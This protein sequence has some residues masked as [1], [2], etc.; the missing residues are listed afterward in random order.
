MSHPTTS[1]SSSYA[2]S[3]SSMS[4]ES[5]TKQKGGFV[6]EPLESDVLFGRGKQTA[7]HPGNRRMHHIVDK[8]SIMYHFQLKAGKKK[9]AKQVYDEVMN[10]GTTRFLKRVAQP[11]QYGWIVVD[12]LT[13]MNKI[14]HALRCR[15]NANRLI[16][17]SQ[18]L[19]KRF[20]LLEG[21]TTAMPQPSKVSNESNASNLASI[22]TSTVFSRRQVDQQTHRGGTSSLRSDPTIVSAQE[23][24]TIAR[25]REQSTELERRLELTRN[26]LG[27]LPNPRN[28]MI[29]MQRSRLNHLLLLREMKN[30]AMLQRVARNNLNP[31][32]PFWIQLHY[33]ILWSC[34]DG[35]IRSRWWY[36]IRVIPADWSQHLLIVSTSTTC[37][38]WQVQ[39]H[40]LF[41]RIE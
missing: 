10:E 2:N 23:V 31:F 8:Y 6:K 25:R 15:K 40:C 32:P 3:S 4:G 14:G 29:E 7:E 18:D 34:R 30:I 37:L 20:R 38:A 1:H 5:S 9:I 13:A 35:I 12:D 33:S 24:T 16:S 22:P 26:D 41:D 21:E 11:D 28:A 27:I 19:A 36:L 39:F 17:K